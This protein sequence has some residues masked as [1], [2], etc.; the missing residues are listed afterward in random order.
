MPV[1]LMSFVTRQQPVGGGQCFKRDWTARLI[2]TAVGTTTNEV[3]EIWT[4]N[5]GSDWIRFTG[6]QKNEADF[7]WTLK[8]STG[9]QHM[10]STTS[11]VSLARETNTGWVLEHT[12]VYILSIS[13]PPWSQRFFLIFLR[14]REPRSGEHESRSGEKEKPLV[15]LDLNL[16]FMLTPTVKRLKLIITKGNNSNSASTY[17]SAVNFFKAG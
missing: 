15:T 7:E 11:L 12:L 5:F 8:K 13:R 14:M 2:S 9:R 1:P 6:W 4:V 17:L 3:L 10:P 16:T